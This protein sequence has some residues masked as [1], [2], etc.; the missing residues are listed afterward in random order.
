MRRQVLKNTLTKFY[1]KIKSKFDKM[2]SICI[3]ETLSPIAPACTYTDFTYH[4]RTVYHTFELLKTKIE[5]TCPVENNSE[6]MLT[7]YNVTPF[8]LLW[9]TTSKI[10]ILLSGSF[11]EKPGIFWNLKLIR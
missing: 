9:T 4:N 7:Y 11:I 1:T 2:V 5:I 6:H 8:H 10:L 3:K